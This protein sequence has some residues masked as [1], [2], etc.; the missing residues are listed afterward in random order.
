MNKKDGRVIL[1]KMGH[2][3]TAPP[4]YIRGFKL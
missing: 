1:N 2:H 3:F 4:A